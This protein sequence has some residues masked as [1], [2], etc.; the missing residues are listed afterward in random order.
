MSKKKPASLSDS[1]RAALRESGQTLYRISKESG[2]PYATLH[3]FM[4]GK[5]AVSMEAL[6]LLCA[7]LGLE[8]SPRSLRSPAR[9]CK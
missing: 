5:R 4:A 3:R 7:Y 1:L 8:L 2:V 9:Q 6:Q